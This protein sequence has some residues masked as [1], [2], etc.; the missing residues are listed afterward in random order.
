[1]TA[2][3]D[4]LTQPHVQLLLRLVLGGL[5]VLSGISKLADRPGF[6]AAVAQY[7]LLPEAW[8]RPFAKS[9]PWLEIALGVMLLLGFGTV[10]A[11]WLALPLFLSFG[12]AIGVNLARGRRFDCHCFGS[13]HSESIGWPA[14]LR[15][16]ALITATLV[17]ALGAS[18]FGA[19]EFAVFGSESELPSA[20]EIVPVVLLAAVIFDALFLLPEVVAFRTGFARAYAV[21]VTGSGHGDGHHPERSVP[22]ER[23]AR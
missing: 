13:L 7:D 15:A 21:R 22:R 20:G 14:L 9:L 18:R 5:L 23:S 3:L 17:V 2:S 1:M 6:R 19:L 4:A 11:A 16:A 8:E 10:A 12:L